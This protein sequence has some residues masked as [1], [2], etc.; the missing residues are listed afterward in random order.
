[1]KYN[2]FLKNNLFLKKLL[3]LEIT[4]STYSWNI[5]Y[6]WNNQYFICLENE[7]VDIITIDDY[8]GKINNKYDKIVRNE[9]EICFM[10]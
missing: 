3:I 6:S 5:T 1:M 7:S 4:S 2:L 9:K 8:Q 10:F